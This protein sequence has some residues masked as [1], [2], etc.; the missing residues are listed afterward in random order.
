MESN[1]STF[2]SFLNLF[3]VQAK[4][5]ENI[6]VVYEDEPQKNKVLVGGGTGFIHKSHLLKSVFFGF[7]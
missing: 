3:I 6:E 4:Q 5:K 1:K 2:Y 7:I